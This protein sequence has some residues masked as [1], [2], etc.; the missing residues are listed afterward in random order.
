MPLLN[1]PAFI[2]RVSGFIGKPISQLLIAEIEAEIARFQRER[3]YPFVSILTPPQEIS[4]GTLRFRVVEFH[5]GT[6]TVAGASPADANAIRDRIRLETGER[7]ASVPLSQDLDW[8][9]RSPFRHIT[10]QFTPG[11]KLGV[12]DLQL[13][14]S[15]Q[16]RWSAFA[17][18]A[19]SGTLASPNRYLVGGSVGDV[20]GFNSV[21]SFQ[22]TGSPNFWA[23]GGWPLGSKTSADYAS[24]SGI[25]SIPLMPRSELDITADAVGQN[26]ADG[27]FAASTQTVEGTA[28]IRSAASN[29]VT[30]AGDL[31]AGIEA[32]RE[33]RTRTF[34]GLVIDQAAAEVYQAA[35]G[36]SDT[37]SGVFP[38]SL[39]ITG[40]GSPGG[41][42]AAN[43]DAAFAA[44]SQGRVT[45]ARY[46]YASVNGSVRHDLFAGF[47]L[48]ET[49]IG[50]AATNPLP[51]TEQA[52]LGGL[53]A[54]RGYVSD[55]GSYD[56]L[57]VLRSELMLPRLDFGAGGGAISIAP[58]T[59]ADLGAGALFGGTTVKAASAGVGSRI[60]IGQ[61][62]TGE[63]AVARAFIAGPATPA[64]A[65]ASY[66]KVLGRY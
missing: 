36:W 30:L 23:N 27:V 50:Q 15:T 52:G 29:F 47:A 45:S 61:A 64:N 46:T 44:Y 31:S 49:F 12:S 51:D 2:A 19:N 32:R 4:D 5:A 18:Y 13:T 62:F 54:V 1:D 24:L 39:T 22:L 40:R 41:L 60:A 34:G 42:S 25:A 17:G 35:V 58:Y 57:A 53:D 26:S 6:I 33:D 9:N 11:T 43:S 37:W 59:F 65:W 3:G 20:L 8:L 38:G 16:R 7:I 10:A 66:V 28:T 55:D 21:L 14:T 56:H 63:V 48:S